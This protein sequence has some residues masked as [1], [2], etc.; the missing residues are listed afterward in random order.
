MR[1]FGTYRPEGSLIWWLQYWKDG[2]FRQESS[3]CE[4]QREA[5]KVLRQKL[6]GLGTCCVSPGADQEPL[7]RDLYLAVE[8]DYE[9]N[10]NR[11]IRIMRGRWQNHLAEQLGDLPAASI[12]ADRIIQY[13]VMRQR[14]GASNGTLNREMATIKRIYSIAIRSKT[15]ACTSRPYIPHLKENSPRKGF[16]SD[17]QYLALANATAKHGLWLRSLLECGYSYGC[18]LGELLNLKVRQVSLE[19]RAITLDPG[20]TKNGEGRL[21]PMS[22]KVFELMEQCVAG[23]GPEQ[24]VFTREHRRGALTRE[25]NVHGVCGV[26]ECGKALRRDNKSGYCYT[27]HMISVR[28]FK[29]R[30][31]GRVTDMR[32]A[33]AEATK[34][35]GCEGLK[36]HDLRRSAIRNMVRS[37]VSEKVAM[38]ISGHE[39]RSV[40]DRY[41]ICDRADLNAAVRKMEEARGR[42]LEAGRIVQATASQPVPRKVMPAAQ[43]AEWLRQQQAQLGSKKR[44]AGVQA[45]AERRPNSM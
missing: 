29:P 8:R 30:N 31:G 38:K 9:M 3:G 2:T 41:D 16:I 37:G 40:F 11:S 5:Q 32:D 35:A 39:T 36:F 19:E 18:R 6:S 23:K 24:C 20:T 43:V 33:W 13:V 44:A 34:E 45:S 42:N 22:E 27:H 1:A 21:L 28:G 25:P 26:K 15:L 14:Q 17:R 4:N 12:T 7:L 10:G